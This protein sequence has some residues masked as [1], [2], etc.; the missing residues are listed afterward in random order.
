[1]FHSLSL[2]PYLP[3]ELWTQAIAFVV[4]MDMDEDVGEDAPNKP[5]QALAAAASS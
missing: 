1:M 2:N 4:I 3:M 5:H